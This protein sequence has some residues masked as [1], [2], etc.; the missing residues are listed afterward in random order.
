M[1]TR[2]EV[3]DIPVED[4]LVEGTLVTPGTLVPGVLFV[5]GWGGS[6]Q[7]YLARARE[8]ASL[9]CICLTFD[10]R[11][12]V[13]TKSQ[14]ETVSREDNFQDV[15][16]AYDT[17]LAQPG[18]DPSAV[19]VVGS[20]YGGYLA[21]IL[22]S[23]RAVRWLALRAPALYKDEDWELP[24]GQLR[25]Q[26]DLDAY[27]KLPVSPEDSIALRACAAFGGD[28]LLVESE[29]DTTIPHQVLVNYRDA[30]AR[31]HSLTYRVIE[32]ADHGLSDAR[33]Q[34]AYTTTLVGWLAEMLG[35]ARGHWA[36]DT[37]RGVPESVEQMPPRLKVVR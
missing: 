2:D 29:H 21:T 23:V 8:I 27:R 6:Q 32:G 13:R 3:I 11:G 22:T 18:I 37:E 17:L 31:A 20:S 9:G 25:K 12:H 26:H 14:Y 16:A 5:H 28:V 19:A 24:K 33:W 34:Q 10:L 4:E 36:A 7:Q 15:V 35:G 1:P 30:C